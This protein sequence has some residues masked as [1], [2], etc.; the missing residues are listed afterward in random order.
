[1]IKSEFLKNTQVIEFQD[2]LNLRINGEQEFKHGYRNLRNG[3]D[4]NCNSIYNA[5]ENYNWNFSCEIPFRGELVTGNSFEE[6]THALE[7]IKGVLKKSLDEKKEDDF[8]KYSISV[9]Q[10]GG[11]KNH[12][13]NTLEGMGNIIDYFNLA[14]ERLDQETVDADAKFTDL[15]LNAGFTKIYSLLIDNFAMYDSR[16]G[17]ALGYL[18]RLYLTEN[19]IDARKINERNAVPAVLRFAYGNSR[20]NQQTNQ[21]INRRNPSFGPYTFPV[22]TKKN[23]F[24]NNIKANWLLKNL[25]ENSKFKDQKS[26]IRALEAALFMIGYSV[27]ENV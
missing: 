21:I 20:G 22:L 11:V 2:W 9:L 18:V 27:I 23:Y 4:W 5:F 26:P 13:I 17:A 24:N 1:M 25:A 19:G 8:L 14:Q 3:N 16:V 15:H 6:S 7:K 10:W 12:N